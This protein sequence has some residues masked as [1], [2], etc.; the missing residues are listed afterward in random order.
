MTQ[1]NSAAD[2]IHNIPDA[3][4]MHGPSRGCD[5]D[6]LTQ[7]GRFL[8]VALDQV[9]VGARR[10]RQ[11]AGKHHARKP[12]TATEVGP[13]LCRWRQAQELEGIRDMAGP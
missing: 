9:N 12:A 13:D 6:G 4:Q 5:A 2:S 8:G 10:F 11:R 3:R 1:S 7:E